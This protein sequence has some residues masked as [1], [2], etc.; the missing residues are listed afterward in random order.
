MPLVGLIAI[1]S[2]SWYRK[3][4]QPNPIITEQALQSVIADLT[5]TQSLLPT[6]PVF[7]VT[8]PHLIY[9]VSAILYIP[10]L[11]L[12][13]YVSLCVLVACAGTIILTWRAPWAIVFRATVWR[14]AWIRWSVYHLWSW[15]SGQVIVPPVASFHPT[16]T[17]AEPGNSLRFLFSVLENQRWWVGLDWTAALLPGERPSWCTLSQHPVS[18]PNAFLLPDNTT[19]YL[20]DNEGRRVKRTATWKWEETEWRVLIRKDGGG[21]SR[22]ERPLP[23]IKEESSNG[24]RLLKAAGR[25]RESGTLTNP[26]S[27][28]GNPKGGTATS[29]GD[30]FEEPEETSGEEPN[31]DIDGWVYGDNK[32]EGG[33]SRGGMGK[34]CTFPGQYVFLYSQFYSIL[35]TD[36]GLVLQSSAKLL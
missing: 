2:S 31:T 10:Y 11:L 1:S 14:S 23:S 21:L 5:T 22:V 26:S 20:L 3:D 25:L 30:Q 6:F 17:T 12:T 15:L 19:V 4:N 13:H 7:S 24:S 8:N 32:W 33:S 9:R 27:T 35:G 29:D 36:S 18:P 16:S 28:A 34:V